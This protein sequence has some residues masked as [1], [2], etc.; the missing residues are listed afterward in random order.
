MPSRTIRLTVNI[1][2]NVAEQTA[3]IASARKISRSKLVVECLR[4]AIA[5]RD[6]QMLIEGYKAMAQEHREFAR[7]S[8]NAA[9]ETLPDW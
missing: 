3:K 9:R 6:R 7:F 1:P 5:E 2:E 8:E 4:Q